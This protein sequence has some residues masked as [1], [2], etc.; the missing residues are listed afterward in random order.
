[1]IKGRMLL[2][3]A[4][5]A[6]TV[7]ASAGAYAAF[8]AGHPAASTPNTAVTIADFATNPAGSVFLQADLTGRSEAQAPGDPGG[9]AVAV[10]RITRNQIM[11]EIA[12]RNMPAPSGI[13]LQ[14]GAAGVSGPMKMNLMPAAVPGSINAIAGVVNLNGSLLNLLLSNPNGF[15]ANLMTTTFPAGAVRG[16]FRQVGSFDFNQILHVG[17]LVSVGSG[18]QEVPQ[19]GEANAHATV[20]LG[21]NTTTL[22]YAAIWSGVN[23]PT[24]LNVNVGASGADGTQAA[25]LFRAPHGLNPTI[26][27]VAG[28]VAGVPAKTLASIR[29]NP[30]AFHTNLLTGRFPAGAVRG[31]LFAATA[32]TVPTT[33]KPVPTTIPMTTKPTMPTKQPTTQPTATM[34]TVPD[35]GMPIVT[36]T[37][38]PPHW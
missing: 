14:Q 33:T 21:A 23:S 25:A 34:P 7:V 22:N 35:T 8:T 5:L 10:L 6:A 37:N 26:I 18:D 13:R 4:A 30:A 12:W 2:A 1:M 38:A 16:Q 32:V 20:F 24:A 19:V 9:Q 27:A 36:P 17:Q 11:Y 29:A 3:V 15:Y 31:Q 28:T